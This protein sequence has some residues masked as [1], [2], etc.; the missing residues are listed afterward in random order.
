M[1]FQ[2]RLKKT[3]SNLVT[4]VRVEVVVTVTGS[5]GPRPFPFRLA[6]EAD[7][8]TVSEDVATSLG[9]PTGGRSPSDGG[10]GRIVKVRFSFPAFEEPSSPGIETTSDWLVVPN[11]S[12]VAL[13]SFQEINKHFDT[14]T[15]ETMMYFSKRKG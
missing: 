3:T 12:G 1:Q 14:M 8:T 10:K 9:L 6:T 7:I 15:D 4:C 13:L 2:L 5:G 11:G